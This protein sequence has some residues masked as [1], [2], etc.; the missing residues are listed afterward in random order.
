MEHAVRTRI[1]ADHDRRTFTHPRGVARI[2]EWGGGRRDP[3]AKLNFYWSIFT[4]VC[5]VD[6]SIFPGVSLGGGEAPSPRLHPASTYCPTETCLKE[7]NHLI[8]VISSL[9]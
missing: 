7:T 9:K 2:F 4:G 3:P 5:F 6:S 1:P 8:Q